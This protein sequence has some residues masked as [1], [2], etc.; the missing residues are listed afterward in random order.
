MDTVNNQ[1]CEIECSGFV[2]Y[3]GIGGWA[4]PP[5]KKALVLGKVLANNKIKLH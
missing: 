4:R 1:Q 5:F 3:Q 2:S